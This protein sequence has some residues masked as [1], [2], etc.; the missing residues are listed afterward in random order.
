MTCKL[1][2]EYTFLCRCIPTADHKNFFPREKF[3]VASCT[4]GDAASAKFIF[5][6][7]AD[8]ARACSCSNDNAERSDIAARSLNR[9]N[10]AGEVEFPCFGDKEFRPEV[11]GLAAHRFRKCLAGGVQDAGI[12]DDF[13]RDGDLAADV[14]SFEN[15]DAEACAGQVDGGGE[16]GRAG[17]DDDGVV[18]GFVVL[19][20]HLR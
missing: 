13:V 16:T 4:I 9:F 10:R 6:F 18:N 19:V 20:A 3:T 5:S 8:S 1:R 15:E 11:F 17:A 14:F 12:V 2:Q 7:E